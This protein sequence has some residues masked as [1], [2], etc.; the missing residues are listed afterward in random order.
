VHRV[1]RD[2]VRVYSKAA[3]RKLHARCQ[4]KTKAGK[5]LRRPQFVRELGAKRKPVVSVFAALQ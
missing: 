5:Q 3:D 2:P 1:R 4:S